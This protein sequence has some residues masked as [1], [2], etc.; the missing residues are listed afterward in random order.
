MNPKS[1]KFFFV[2][3]IIICN[4]YLTT[5]LERVGRPLYE[6]LSKGLALRPTDVSQKYNVIDTFFNFNIM[7]ITSSK[8]APLEQTFF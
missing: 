1:V 5:R 8:D 2:I 3:R 6:A 7:K 4:D